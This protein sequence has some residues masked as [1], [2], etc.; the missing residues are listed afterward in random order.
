MV[1]KTTRMAIIRMIMVVC[2]AS[3]LYFFLF[4]DH[5]DQVIVD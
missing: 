1:M 2:L 5:F 4:F 3:F